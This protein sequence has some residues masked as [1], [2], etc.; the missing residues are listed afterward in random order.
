MAG[1]TKV[2]ELAAYNLTA[3][4]QLAAEVIA[5]QNGARP[6]PRSIAILSLRGWSSREMEE[7][8]DLGSFKLAASA[9]SLL[10]LCFYAVYVV[11]H[12]TALKFG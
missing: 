4:V 7:L 2:R 11:V 10:V 5:R 6:V 8:N 3:R 1:R 9:G 12:V